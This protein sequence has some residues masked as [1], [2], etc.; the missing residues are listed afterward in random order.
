M[1]VL[2]SFDYCA[3][4][5]V[6]WKI[7]TLWTSWIFLCFLFLQDGRI[8]Y[9]EFV[10]MMQKGNAGFGKKGIQN[11][12][13]FREALKLGWLWQEVRFCFLL[14]TILY[15]WKFHT[16]CKFQLLAYREKKRPIW[17]SRCIFIQFSCEEFESNRIVAHYCLFCCR[18]VH[19]PSLTYFFFNVLNLNMFDFYHSDFLACARCLLSLISYPLYIRFAWG[20]VLLPSPV[21]PI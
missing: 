8:D 7:S 6:F 13:G 16:S 4:G 17:L 15:N 1:C 9:N 18:T 12:I 21:I 14:A 20:L 2:F 3:W 19:E 5:I 10:E 11:N